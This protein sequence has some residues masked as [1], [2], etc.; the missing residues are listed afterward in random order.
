MTIK[1]IFPQILLLVSVGFLTAQPDIILQDYGPQNGKAYKNQ[2]MVFSIELANLSAE[3]AIAN[4]TS[5]NAYAAY[6]KQ[7]LDE[8]A[9]SDSIYNLEIKEL[10]QGKGINEFEVD[11]GSNSERNIFW[12]IAQKD[13]KWKDSQ[14]NATSMNFP[15]GE[16]QLNGF[17]RYTYFTGIPAASTNDLNGSIKIRFGLKGSL[18][19]GENP[20]DTIWSN[21]VEMELLDGRSPDS[22]SWPLNEQLNLLHFHYVSGSYTE[23]ISAADQILSRDAEHQTAI[24]FKALILF[25]QEN[26]QGA[27]DLIEPIV[28]AAGDE[29]DIHKQ[30]HPIISLYNE[31]MIKI[32]EEN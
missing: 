21:P 29:P 20:A 5:D 26:I 25:E 3:A 27:K 4:N 32:M 13:Q 24:Y 31:I 12:Q 11:F 18:V 19:K 16:I 8:G 1:Y 17:Q 14:V 15:E 6:L 30:P 10:G 9:L 7:Q 22:A 2:P 23:A 28:E